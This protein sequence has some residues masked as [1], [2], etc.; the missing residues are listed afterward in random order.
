MKKLIQISLMLWF[1]SSAVAQES[2]PQQPGKT[3]RVYDWKDLA[4]QHELS[5]GEVISM[6]GISVL[7]IEKTND[8]PQ[9]LT[10]LKISDPSVIE[11]ANFLRCD[12][13]CENV[14][15]AAGSSGPSRLRLLSL[16]P[17]AAPGGDEGSAEQLGRRAVGATIYGT[18]NWRPCQIGVAR[19]V[20]FVDFPVR[21]EVRLSLTGPGTIYLRPI[22]LLGVAGSWWWPNQIGLI[23]GIGGSLIGCLGGL[24]GLLISMGKARNFVLAAAKCFIAL[25]ILLTI[26]GLVAVVFKQ[27]YAVWYALLLPGVVLILVF[28]LNLHSIQRRY[29][30]LEIR[31][32]TSIDATGG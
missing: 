27:P 32:M 12:V 6:D 28:S 22:K 16:F 13:K 31:R 5:V 26:A 1:V 21:L 24:I 23:G 2:P 4:R 25:G 20:M 3:L 18:S 14:Q 11:K 30:E 7:K 15:V 10:L 19:N 29:D 9:E 17:P 8:S